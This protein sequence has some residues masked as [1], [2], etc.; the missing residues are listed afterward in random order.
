MTVA[1]RTRRPPP[2]LSLVL[3]LGA[4]AATFL[5]L[6]LA[7]RLAMPQDLAFFDGS[8]IK[9]RSERPGLRYELVPGGYAASYVGV[10]VSVNRLGL[11]DREIAVPK[12][13]GTV[14]IL[15]VGDSVTF[16]Y[17]VR[18][19]DTYLKVLEGRLQHATRGGARYE[20]VNAGIEECGLDAYYHAVR[21]LG[22]LLQPDLVLVGIV[23]N[24]VQRYDDFDRPARPRE[25]SIEPGLARRAHAALLARSQLYYAGVMASRSLLYRFHVLDVADLYG[26]PLRAVRGD[27]AS[28]ERAWASSLHVLE[29]LVGLARAQGLRLVL[30]VFPVEVQL[31]DAAI[32]R[33]RRD[34]GVSVPVR[35]LDGE[36]QRRLLA[37]GA[38][39]D[40][41]VIDVLPALRAAGG[42]DLY[43][44]NGAV[45]FDPVHFSPRGHRVVGEAIHRALIERRLLPDP[46]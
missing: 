41:P 45:R 43:L 17:G 5:A 13:A 26:S 22:P 35:A 38:S 18:L 44:R 23:L 28:I 27:G 40:V 3:A 31:D 30:V 42:T 15:G 1:P 2:V 7:V 12:A 32:V 34:Y 6:E 4:V 25:A 37:F 36:P 29:E 21:T 11:R 46:A 8:A 33:Y 19:E 9:R 24:D 39:H 20:A 10:P 16:G 14:R